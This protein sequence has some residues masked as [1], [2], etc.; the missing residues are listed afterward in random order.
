MQAIFPTST[1]T[2]TTTPTHISQYNPRHRHHTTTPNRNR[3]PTYSTTLHTSRPWPSSKH[4]NSN[5]S[6]HSYYPPTRPRTPGLC[7]RESSHSSVTARRH[8][9]ASI[10]VDHTS[11]HRLPPQSLPQHQRARFLTTTRSRALPTP[12]THQTRRQPIPGTSRR[13][14]L[15][16]PCTPSRS[17]H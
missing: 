3:L 16:N 14:K 15:T 13:R 6:S 4:N 5:T 2:T 8:L 1:N 11:A 9:R 10:E 17:I 12:S 7:T